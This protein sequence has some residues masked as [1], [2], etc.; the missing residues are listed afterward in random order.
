MNS[1]GMTEAR[2]A[3][4][5]LTLFEKVALSVVAPTIFLLFHFANAFERFSAVVER[6]EEFQLDEIFFALML[7]GFIGYYYSLRSLSSLRR[8]IR[9]REEAEAS[10]LQ[11]ARHD[12]LTGLPNRRMLAAELAMCVRSETPCAV[13][14]VDLDH[15]KPVNDLHGHELGDQLLI[16]AAARL[17]AIDPSVLVSRLGGDEFACIVKEQADEAVLARLASHIGREIAREFVIDGR[18]ITIGASIGIARAPEDFFTPE[19]LLRA[20]DLAMYEAKHAGRG[21]YHFFHAEMD[22]RLRL[23]ARLEADIRE[24][25]HNG[26]IKPYFQ[27]VIHLTDNIVSGFEALARWEHP[28][29]GMVAPDTF[30]PILEDIGL[31]DELMTVMLVE[32]CRAAAYWPQECSLAV[33]ISPFQLRDPSLARRIIALLEMHRFAPRR[34]VVEVTENAIIEDMEQAAAIIRELQAAGI[35][36]A[37]DDFGKGYSSL[38]H[39]RQLHFDHLKIDSSFVRSMDCMESRKI[40]RAVAALG[41]ALGMPVTAEGVETREAA[42]ALRAMGC[43]DAQGYYFGRAVPEDEASAAATRGRRSGSRAA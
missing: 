41:K 2:S 16:E 11:L 13:L 31:A 17:E 25:L 14:L 29:L 35:R 24:A 32:G 5:V 39:L 34:L 18:R 27:P 3:E 37:L 30:V 12:S 26:Q 8:E 23:R 38:T 6:Y 40:V 19:D 43:D 9:R 4:K 10:A 36:V 7:S 21:C 33:N 42:E 15:F 22:A 20:A 1:I 28:Q